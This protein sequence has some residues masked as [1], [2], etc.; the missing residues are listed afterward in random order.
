MKT[1]LY[2]FVPESVGPFELADTVE[3]LL[4]PFRL[5]HEDTIQPH[6]RFDYL[7]EFEPTLNC[8]ATDAELPPQIRSEYA[9]H[10]TR[11]SRLSSDALPGAVVTTHGEWHDLSD[12]GYRMMNDESANA[13]ARQ[14][15][16]QHFW[17]LVD[18]SPNCW[19]IE[20]WAHS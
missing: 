7:C 12:F 3:A 20:T 8:A 5:K 19:V 14:N 16:R 17:G 4:E 15:W 10:I 13:S 6:W 18:E 11:L 9:G 2:V 1:L